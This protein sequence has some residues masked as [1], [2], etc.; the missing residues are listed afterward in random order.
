MPLLDLTDNELETIK[1]ALGFGAATCEQH[2]GS[3][4]N[5]AIAPALKSSAR[6]YRDLCSR[7]EEGLMEVAP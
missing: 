6:A 1:L 3:A 7:L 5:N 2:A 4:D